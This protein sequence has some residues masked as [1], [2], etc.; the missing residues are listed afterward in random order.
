MVELQTRR[1]AAN[2]VLMLCESEKIPKRLADQ[3]NLYLVYG[4]PPQSSFLR[5]ML[6]HQV[7]EALIMSSKEDVEHA[8]SIAM[9]MHWEMPSGAH[10]SK[11]HVERWCSDIRNSG[12]PFLRAH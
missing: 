4:E 9:I 7:Y 6:Q 12:E 3:L 10:G 1:D 8:K 5:L 2:R 11:E